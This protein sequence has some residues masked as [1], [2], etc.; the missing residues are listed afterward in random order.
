MRCNVGCV[1]I[2]MSVW[3]VWIV[4]RY[5]LVEKKAFNGLLKVIDIQR[6]FT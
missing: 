3:R 1:K 4:I 2:I 5:F 6:I